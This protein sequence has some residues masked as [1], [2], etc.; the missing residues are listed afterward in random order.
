M[1]PFVRNQ[2]SQLGTTSLHVTACLLTLLLLAH[3]GF[4]VFARA[5][6]SPPTRR[7]LLIGGDRN[8][9]PYEYLDENGQP[10]GFNVDLS[11]AVGEAMGVPVRFVLMDWSRLHEALADGTV[12]VLQRTP[13]SNLWL[14]EAELTPPHTTINHAIF[15]RKGT[16]AVAS[17]EELAGRKVIV[18]PG[19]SINDI[20]DGLGYEND[21]IFS[22]TPVGGLRR[23]DRG[24]GDYAV[25]A[26]LP[27]LFAMEREKLDNLRIVAKSVTTQPYGF[28]V[29]HGDDATL[30]LLNE[31]LALVKQSGRYQELRRKWFGVMDSQAFSFNMVLKYAAVVLGPLL[32]LLGLAALWTRS[33]KKQVDQRT[34]SLTDALEKLRE[35]QQQLVQADKMAAL[36]VLVSGVAHEINN[37]NGLI[38]LNVPILKKL[39]AEAM[40]VL[41]DVF[42]EKG[43]FPLGGGAYS[44]IRDKLPRIVDVVEESAQR[45][46]R[47]VDDLRDFSRVAPA[48]DHQAFDLGEA[49]RK[50]SRLVG[51][52]IH[53]ATSRFSL[54]LAPDLP[55]VWGSPTRIEQVAVNLLLNACQALDSPEAAIAVST[56]VSDD[57]QSVVLTVA[58]EGSGITPEDLPRITDPFFT[59]K[60]AS[61]GTGLGLSVSAGIV[62]EHGG[63]LDFVS[64]PGSGT[65]ARLRL[66]VAPKTA[67]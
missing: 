25:V 3:P 52:S 48:S 16:P 53:K 67:P 37:P 49:A 34:R 12:D 59:T 23:L 17:L 11:K 61:G 38:L 18:H 1:Q 19:G 47:I 39:N 27:G 65:T 44:R 50:A 9:P 7:P 60:R 4:A 6:E 8:Y 15:A 43:D 54:D 64:R 36:G 45:I 51:S 42:E 5:Q 66:P 22:K 28:A 56:A 33:L 20:L 31:G 62:Q 26:M 10:A 29:R 14:R 40:R 41:D 55:P 57:G 46:R 35:N 58:D 32:L 24:E 21:L 13:Y 2:A 63:S 30:S